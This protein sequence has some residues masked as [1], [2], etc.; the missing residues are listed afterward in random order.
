M[1]ITTWRSYVFS[2]A[3]SHSGAARD[4]RL[5]GHNFE[6]SI[7]VSGPIDE[8]SG[9][10]IGSAAMDEAASAALTRFD[11]RHLN[12]SLGQ[13]D[14]TVPALATALW[15]KLAAH[16]PPGP[17]LHGVEIAEDG[18]AA[19]R[20]AGGALLVVA[21]GEFSAAHRTHAP[22]LTDDENLTLYGRCNNPAGHGH[23][24]RVEVEAP[25]GVAIDQAAWMAF[26]HRNLSADVPE[27]AGR[28]V[29]TE[30]IAALIASRAPGARRVRVWELSDFYAE[31]WPGADVYRL[32]R[33]Y[34][35]RAAHRLHD[36]SLA[37]Q[38]GRRLHGRCWSPEPHGHTYYATVEVAGQLDGRTETAYDLAALDQVAERAIGALDSV[39]LN[40]EVREFHERPATGPNLARHV[41]AG[42]ATELGAALAKVTVQPVAGEQ[43]VMEG[44]D[45]GFPD[46]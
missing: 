25:P 42:L 5:H 4:R 22:G 15:D 40:T 27:L 7:G 26:D 23:N 33:R 1:T 8:R 9:L 19:A 31:Y 2:A 36:P 13:D 45:E 18:G 29:V 6:A 28:N 16:L 38:D 35:F 24:Y 17:A 14:P 37:D 44:S 21:R 20:A 30:A 3:H 32:G 46:A 10:V 43:T 11:R 41:W 34:P 39:D 12:K